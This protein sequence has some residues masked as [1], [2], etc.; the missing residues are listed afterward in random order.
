M[1]KFFLVTLTTIF[2]ISCSNSLPE[3]VSKIISGKN[4]VLRN[5]YSYDEYDIAIVLKDTID[6]SGDCE[7]IAFSKDKK[8]VNHITDK[9]RSSNTDIL[10]DKSYFIIDG[11]EYLNIYDTDQNKFHQIEERGVIITLVKK[12]D[13]LFYTGEYQSLNRINLKTMDIYKYPLV[14]TG[15]GYI[16]QID[17]ELYLWYYG[18]VVY[19]VE[20]NELKKVD[21]KIVDGHNKI[22]SNFLKTT[23]TE[24]LKEYEK[25]LGLK[26]YEEK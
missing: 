20:G 12:D 10:L 18:P 16:Y 17:D 15:G 6:F 4:V 14:E 19:K 8:L 2:F 3:E 1:K 23:D 9:I 13:F 11:Y 24:K 21:P 7:I 22:E 5:V 26:R 25:Y